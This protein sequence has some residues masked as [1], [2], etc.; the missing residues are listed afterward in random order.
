MYRA[1][2]RGSRSAGLLERREWPLRGA[3]SHRTGDEGRQ[4]AMGC[5]RSNTG[6]PTPADC[7]R[8]RLPTRG[9]IPPP[10]PGWHPGLSSLA[11]S[12]ERP[13]PNGG[14]GAIHTYGSGAPH[15][16]QNLAP[17]SVLVRHVTH[18][19]CSRHLI[20]QPIAATSKPSRATPRAHDM[21]TSELALTVTLLC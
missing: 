9:A 7:G 10:P 21:K 6:P 2:P 13:P 18:A 4:V 12:G 8:A 17:S 11:T 3:A 1:N 14:G 5:P 19:G 15:L 20:H 16:W